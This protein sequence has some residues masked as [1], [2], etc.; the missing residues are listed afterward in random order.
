M[1][2]FEKYLISLLMLGCSTLMAMENTITGDRIEDSSELQVDV[3][4]KL[5]SIEDN[6]VAKTVVKVLELLKPPSFNTTQIDGAP[7]YCTLEYIQWFTPKH[8]HPDD[9]FA[10]TISLFNMCNEQTKGEHGDF[11]KKAYPEKSLPHYANYKG[12][13][14]KGIQRYQT[15]FQ[16]LASY[17]QGENEENATAELKEKYISR[18]KNNL[19][20]SAEFLK[21]ILDLKTSDIIEKYLT[22]SHAQKVIIVGCG[23]R[24]LQQGLLCC[25]ESHNGHDGQLTFDI[26]AG[27]LPNIVCSVNQI[28]VWKYIEN[29]ILDLVRNETNCPIGDIFS[30]DA[31]KEIYRVLKVSGRFEFLNHELTDI[32]NLKNIGFSIMR[33]KDGRRVAIK[34]L[35]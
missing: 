23:A 30:I 34:D 11:W 12:W 1:V 7:D 19:P 27:M 33:D 28:E 8:M 31:L 21:K 24:S 29:D 9:N 32:E 10:G 17:L 3:L 25:C 18:L 20:D 4:I 22:D 16:T 35:K 26:S 14:N 2:K 5:F 13:H 6:E 15:I